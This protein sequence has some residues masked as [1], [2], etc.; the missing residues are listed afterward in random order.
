MRGNLS[1]ESVEQTSLCLAHPGF[2]CFDDADAIAFGAVPD[3]VMPKRWSGGAQ[4]VAAVGEPLEFGDGE[5]EPVRALLDGV[6][7]GQTVEHGPGRRRLVQFDVSR[8]C[9]PGNRPRCECV[10]QGRRGMTWLC[11]C[12]TEQAMRYI[13]GDLP[14]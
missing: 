3:S 5:T 9:R 10:D 14:G 1:D 11:P 6:E 13:G 12:Q 2:R 8:H 7:I 4:P